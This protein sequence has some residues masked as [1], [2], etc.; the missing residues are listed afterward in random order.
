MSSVIAGRRILVAED[1]IIV[2]AMLEDMLNELGATVV[3]PAS[4]LSEAVRLASTAQI[5]AAVLDVNLRG[6]RI[7]PV[8]LLLQSR[9][10]PFLLATGYGASIGPIADGVPT[11]DKPY[12]KDMLKR[13]LADC[14]VSLR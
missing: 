4:K 9:G 14:L 12:T 7:D 3:G 6:E 10:V 2:S 11:I 1:E 5:D 13:A 8:A